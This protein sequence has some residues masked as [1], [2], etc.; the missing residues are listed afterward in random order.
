[1]YGHETPTRTAT[2]IGAVALLV[3]LLVSYAESAA[4]HK[5]RRHEV[6]I[7]GFEF[8]PRTLRAAVGDTVVWINQDIVPHTATDS[9]GKWDSGSLQKNESW[10]Y[11]VRARGNHKY[12]CAL[13]PTMKG[14]IVVP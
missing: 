3:G 5:P 6:R 4:V 2:V 12:L 14:S 8:Q 1:M 7:E 10:K 9:A 11:V 13:H